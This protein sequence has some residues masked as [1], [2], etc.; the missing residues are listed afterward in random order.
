MAKAAEEL[1]AAADT[2]NAETSGDESAGDAQEGGQSYSGGIT[3]G[4]PT[5]FPASVP[6]YGGAQI[7]EASAYGEDGYTVVY[8]VSAGYSEVIAFYMTAIPWL[9]D[10][11]IGEDEAYFEGIELDDGAVLIN[12]LTISDAD[13]STQVFMTLRDYNNDGLTD[14][15]EYGDED[16]NETESDYNSITTLE[17]KDGYPEEV[18]PLFEGLKL[19]TSSGTPSGDLYSIEGV[20]PPGSFDSAV[21]FYQSALGGS[22]E[23]FDTPAMK[24]AQFEGENGE[25]SYSVYVADIYTSGNTVIQI[26]ITK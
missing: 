25:W 4:L 21:A 9:D 14:D 26:S 7:I 5:G 3:E 18:V 13:G 16:V 8:Q 1:A 15:T 11:G 24:T 10:S 17:L 2:E 12:G 6:I 19:T 23:M 22:P 20:A